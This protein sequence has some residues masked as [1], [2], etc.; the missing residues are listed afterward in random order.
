ME[1]KLY[2]ILSSSGWVTSW[3]NNKSSGIPFISSALADSYSPLSPQETVPIIRHCPNHSVSYIR[4][5][6]E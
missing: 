2:Q 4:E 1:K 6:A 3:R 5:A